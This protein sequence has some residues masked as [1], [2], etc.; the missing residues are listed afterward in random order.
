MKQGKVLSGILLFTIVILCIF[1]SKQK[2]TEFFENSNKIPKKIWTYWDNESLPDVVEKCIQT[3]RKHNPEYTVIVLNKNNLKEYLPDIDFTKIKHITDSPQ[4]YSDM[5]RLHT[6]SK[7]GGIWSDASIICLKS[8]DTWI[9]V[10]QEENNCDF[11]GFYIERFTL[12]EYKEYSPVIENWFFACSDNC[13]FVKDWLNEFLRINEF[14][15]VDEYVDL[16]VK[17]GVNIQ[18]ISGPVYLSMHVACQ[19]ILQ[20]GPNKPYTFGLLKAEDTAFKYLTQNNW[21][22]NKAIQNLLDCKNEKTEMNCD[23]FNSPIIKLRGNDRAE[24]EK[25]NY[26]ILFSG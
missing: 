14:E 17:E 8:Y 11:I 12:S 4:K 19:K 10:L 3:W 9:P 22:T 25:E 6:L 13:I 26:N 23:F 18:N 20:Q 7:Y 2:S 21:E 5:V 1:F 16:V 24:L 15:T